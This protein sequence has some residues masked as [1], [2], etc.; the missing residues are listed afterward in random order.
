MKETSFQFKKNVRIVCDLVVGD[1]VR[2]NN[3]GKRL[4]GRDHKVEAL[5][6]KPGFCESS[7]R[8][9]ISGYDQ[10]LDSGWLIKQT[11]GFSGN[12]APAK[13]TFNG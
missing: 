7:V 3:Y 11:Q 6:F 13:V 4:D 1:T 2:T 9:K 5:E 8:V 12:V 10:M